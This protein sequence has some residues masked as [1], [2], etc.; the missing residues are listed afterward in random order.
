MDLNLRGASGIDAIRLAREANPGARF[1]MLSTFDMSEDI[2]RALEAG[3]FGYLLKDASR[4]EIIAAVEAVHTGQRFLPPQVEQRLAERGGR[5]ELSAKEREILGF[6][7][8]GRTNK[9]IGAALSITELTVKGH[10]KNI[11]LKMRVTDRTEAAIKAVWEGIVHL[12]NDTLR[13]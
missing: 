13:R 12:N 8:Q 9:E 2:H 7:V 5:S 3:A 6:I 11:F 10:L 1:I 4:Q